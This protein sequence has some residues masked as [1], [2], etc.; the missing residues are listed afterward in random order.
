MLEYHMMSKE[1]AE[2]SILQELELSRREVYRGHVVPFFEESTEEENRKK[3]SGFL[4]E[5]LKVLSSAFDKSLKNFRTGRLQ[6]S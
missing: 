4:Q 6:N 3:R 1:C 5:S 2:Q